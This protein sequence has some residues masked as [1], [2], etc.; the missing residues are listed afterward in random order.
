[1][2]NSPGHRKSQA[3]NFQFFVICE[4]IRSTLQAPPF[5]LQN[6]KFHPSPLSSSKPPTPPPPFFSASYFIFH[7]SVSAPP[8]KTIS[9]KTPVH[10]HQKFY[11]LIN[12][13]TLLSTSKDYSIYTPTSTSANRLTNQQST[14]SFQSHSRGF[15]SQHFISYTVLAS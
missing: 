3:Q 7:I 12:F 9:A 8:P 13:P 14:L 15:T 2:I 10:I 5:F 6:M 11:N 4:S 1:M